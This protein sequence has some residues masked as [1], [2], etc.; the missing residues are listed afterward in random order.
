MKWY[1]FD[2]QKC[3]L[4][5]YPS[6]FSVDFNPINVSYSGSVDLPQHF[7]RGVNICPVIMNGRSGLI[8][9]VFLGRPLF[10]A[11]LSVFLPTS[12]LLFMSHMV[13]VF[14]RDHLEMVIE[15]N[16]TLLLVLATL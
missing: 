10:S 5:I 13:K 3:T 8:V 15:A 14:G 11:I 16:L 1:P 7:V 6:A 4:K 9:E 2:T 12:I